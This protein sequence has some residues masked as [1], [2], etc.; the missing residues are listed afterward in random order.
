MLSE[1][2]ET[3]G[4]LAWRLKWIGAEDKWAGKDWGQ[5]P[6]ELSEYATGMQERAWHLRMGVATG[7]REGSSPERIFQTSSLVWAL[8]FGCF[9]MFE[10][11]AAMS[12]ACQF[13][14][15]DGNGTCI[16]THLK[17]TVRVYHVRDHAPGCSLPV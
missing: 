11:A 17:N 1:E 5:S 7:F 13:F 6:I 4:C 9:A 14:S 8:G 10:D 16:G 3:H 12:P 15:R 2:K